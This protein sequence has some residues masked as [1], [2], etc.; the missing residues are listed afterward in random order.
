VLP[1]TVVSL[2]GQQEMKH[3]DL[4]AP[5]YRRFDALISAS[6]GCRLLF[7]VNRIPADWS[8]APAEK[9]PT[10][11]EGA[12]EVPFSCGLWCW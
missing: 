5:S 8:G 10:R 2:H 3:I 6:C 12:A 11:L 1:S 9:A 7:L 4:R